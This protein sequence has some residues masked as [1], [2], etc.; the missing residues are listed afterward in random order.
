MEG[1][2]SLRS[3]YRHLDSYDTRGVSHSHSMGECVGSLR[4]R[5]GK[6]K[7]GGTRRIPHASRLRR[8]Q[9]THPEY[10]RKGDEYIRT[11][12]PL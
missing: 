1:T 8:K 12:S 11:E 10:Y 4:R 7:I 3:G 9:R 5:I 6:S 2:R